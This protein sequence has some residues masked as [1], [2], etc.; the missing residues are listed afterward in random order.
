MLIR[1]NLPLYPLQKR[2]REK[3]L[4]QLRNKGYFQKSNN[5]IDSWHLSR[6]SESQKSLGL[7]KV[8]RKKIVTILEFCPQQ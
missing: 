2:E 7:F 8:L 1:V 5:K 3:I 4:K 6:N